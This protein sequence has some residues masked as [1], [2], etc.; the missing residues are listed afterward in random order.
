MARARSSGTVV[1]AWLDRFNRNFDEGVRILASWPSR[2]SASKSD[3][4]RTPLSALPGSGGAGRFHQPCLQQWGHGRRMA[5]RQWTPPL[6]VISCRQWRHRPWWSLSS[7]RSSSINSRESSHP[8][9]DSGEGGRS[10]SWPRRTPGGRRL[11]VLAR[12]RGSPSSAP[13]S[14]LLPESC[15]SDHTARCALE[16][17]KNAR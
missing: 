11:P 15:S 8:A 2:T 17:L 3:E 10:R 1:V 9:T 14:R 7:A 13:C 5:L 4:G 12:R 16:R 6:A